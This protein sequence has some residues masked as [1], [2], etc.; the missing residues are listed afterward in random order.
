MWPADKLHNL[1]SLIRDVTRHGVGTMDRFNAS[2]EQILW[3]HNKVVGAIAKHRDSAPV[4]EIRDATAILARVL[5]EGGSA[6]S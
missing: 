2:P 5:E 4:D 6:Q 3:F 1:T